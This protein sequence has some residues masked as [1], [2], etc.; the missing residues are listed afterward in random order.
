MAKP[1]ADPGRRHP[2]QHYRPPRATNRD[3]QG[4]PRPLRLGPGQFRGNRRGPSQPSAPSFR[5]RSVKSAGGGW[6]SKPLDGIAVN[7][8]A[9][10]GLNRPK[11]SAGDAGGAGPAAVPVITTA[12]RARRRTTTA[13][14]WARRTAITLTGRNLKPPSWRREE[15]WRGGRSGLP[16]GLDRMA[17]ASK[18]RRR[19]PESEDV[20]EIAPTVSK[21][22]ARSRRESTERGGAEKTLAKTQRRSTLRILFELSKFY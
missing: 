17:P 15:S 6:G 21:S 13:A 5:A 20:E 4:R 14:P 11:P 8:R 3:D 9:W 19:A 1:W 18:L 10:T 7:A 16:F 22:G 2:R 12:P